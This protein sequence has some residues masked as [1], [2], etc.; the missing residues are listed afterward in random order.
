MNRAT[1]PIPEWENFD[2]LVV[3]LGLVITVAFPILSGIPLIGYLAEIMA[4]YFLI[5]YTV[6]NKMLPAAIGSIGSL[7]FGLG[8]FGFNGLVLT[9]WAKVV[10]PALAFGILMFKGVRFRH[11]FMAGVAAAALS[12]LALFLAER[13]LIYQGLDMATEWME[14]G[15]PGLAGDQQNVSEMIT[16][17]V[18]LFKRLLPGTLALS[19]VLQL[20]LGWLGVLIY[21]RGIGEFIPPMVDFYF[22]KMPEY[23]IYGIGFFMLAR[24]VGTDPI[25]I[26]ADNLILFGGL[27]Y[28]VCGF[29]LFEY[30]LKKLRLSL[31]LRI[32]F[33]IGILL[34]HIPGLILAA[35]VGIFDSYFDFRKVRA[36]MIG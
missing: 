7:A 14:G 4:M 24:L 15:L 27:F 3:Y 6:R 18:T 21:M 16:Q 32:M 22:W 17:M 33:Y 11:A 8:L 35:L 1:G 10:L 36:K 9:A 23:F 29:S 26:A 12:A 13:N 5:M 25:K 30:Y 19:V 2:R 20:F 34:L 28:A 31:F